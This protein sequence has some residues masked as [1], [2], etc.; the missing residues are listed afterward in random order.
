M[1]FIKDI[2]D[3]LNSQ[4]IMTVGGLIV[5][6]YAIYLYADLAGQ[7]FDGASA[8]IV[9]VVEA[10]I[11]DMKVSDNDDKELKK[12][13]VKALQDNTKAIQDLQTF[14]RTR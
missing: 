9:R 5:A 12:E 3:K 7:K 13:L 10:H 4:T 8:N 14:M 1:T 6:G 2:M 11:E